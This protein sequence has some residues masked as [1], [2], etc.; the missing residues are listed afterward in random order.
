MAQLFG[1][2]LWH[3]RHQ[4][5]LTQTEL[6]QH[7]ASQSHIDGLENSKEGPSLRLVLEIALFFGVS[8]DYLLRDTVSVEDI[9]VVALSPTDPKQIPQLFG[10]KLRTLRGQHNMTQ[11]ALAITLGL[12]RHAFI[13]KL[14]TGYKAPPLDLVVQIADFFRVTTDY[15][16][17]DSIAVGHMT[18]TPEA[19]ASTET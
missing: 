2:K 16:L 19:R 3:L 1:A 10:A 7:F 15:L 9:A 11:G 17:L 18:Y 5:G 14:E 13:S 6:A 8:T 12:T 4:R